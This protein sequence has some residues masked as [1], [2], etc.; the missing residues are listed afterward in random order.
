MNNAKSRIE[1]PKRKRIWVPIAIIAA[2]LLAGAATLYILRPDWLPDWLDNLL[3]DPPAPEMSGLVVP[4]NPGGTADLTTRALLNIAAPDMSIQ[5]I[6]GANGATGLNE[7]WNAAHDGSRVLGTNLFSLVTLRQMGFTD[8]GHGDWAVWLTTY[9]PSV[10]AVAADSPH[11]TLGDLL[12]AARAN[13]LRCANAGNGTLGFVA[14]HLFADGVGMDVKHTAYSGS[15]PA[16]NAVTDGDADYIVALSSEMI[17]KL[18][19]GELRALASLSDSTVSLDGKA[20]PPASGTVP[21]LV[22]IEP[23]GEYY[24]MMVPGDVS[25]GVLKGYDTQWTDAAASESFGTF[26]EEKGLIQLEVSRAHSIETT[27]R[28][29]SLVCWTLYETGCVNIS[30]ESMKP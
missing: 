10:I 21:E 24:G 9:A 18:R 28:I 12:A 13:E 7:V 3:P 30:P 25:S 17:G 2:V 8:T 23:F 14:A 29:A 15:N 5:N 22:N 11:Q 27:D 19:S 20:I 16:M 1:K 4:W 26:A 6:H